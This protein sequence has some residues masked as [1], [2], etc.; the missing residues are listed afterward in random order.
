MIWIGPER[1]SVDQTEAV[2]NGAAVVTVDQPVVTVE[3]PGAVQCLQGVLTNDVEAYGVGGFLYGAVLT[4]KGMITCDLWTAWEEADRLELYPTLDGV[5]AINEVFQKYFPPR[6]ARTT[7]HTSD[8]AVLRLVGPQAH[9]VAARAGFPV[10]DQGHVLHASEHGA[11]LT[12]PPLDAPFALQIVVAAEDREETARKLQASGATA[13]GPVAL[14]VTRLLS[15]WPRLGVEIDDKTLPQAVRFDENEGV[16]YTKGCYTGQETVARV[17]FRGH[18]NRR[19][20]GLAW[21]DVPQVDSGVI[22]HAQKN[23]GRVTTAAWVGEELGWIG[24]AV[25]RREVDIG[26]SVTA[27]QSAARVVDLPFAIDSG[28]LVG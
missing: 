5:A 28:G 18:P 6:L 21:D 15:G 11:T 1:I 12:R 9:A 24:L 3:G 27:A 19:L 7:E 25:L 13:A 22:E 8:R 4:T 2:I 26:T 23:V 16:S 17:H 10:P 20:L 14:D